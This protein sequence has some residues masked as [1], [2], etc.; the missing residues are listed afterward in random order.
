MCVI[1]FDT[2]AAVTVLYKIFIEIEKYICI[3]IK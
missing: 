3:N 2:N 1:T